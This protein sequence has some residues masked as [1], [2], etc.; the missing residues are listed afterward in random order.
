VEKLMEISR[1]AWLKSK[2]SNKIYR[3]YANPKSFLDYSDH[4]AIQ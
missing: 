4:H 2:S 3:R 1:Q